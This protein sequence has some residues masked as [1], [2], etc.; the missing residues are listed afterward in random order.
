MQEDNSFAY[1]AA[2]CFLKE[3]FHMLSTVCRAEE[4]I[5][6]LFLSSMRGDK[7]G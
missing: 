4:E 7:S 1:W 6:E 3:F 2:L 5:Y